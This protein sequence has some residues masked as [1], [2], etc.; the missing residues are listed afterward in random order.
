MSSVSGLGY[1]PSVTPADIE[2]VWAGNVSATGATINA[3]S[4]GTPTLLYGTD[5]GLTDPDNLSGTEGNDDVWSF[6][7]SGLSADTVYYYSFVGWGLTATFRTFPTE[8]TAHS[9]SIAAASCAGQSGGDYEVGD[10]SNTPTLDHIA[11]RDLAL[12]IHLGDRGYPDITTDSVSAFRTNYNANM[13]MTKQAA[14]HRAM[15]VAYVWDDHDF[16]DN[17]SHAATASKPAAQTVYR[18]HVP[19]WTLPSA[20]GIYQTF[21][22]GRVRFIL[23]DGRSFKSNPSDTDDSSKTLLGATQKQ[24]VK[25]TLDNSTEPV[26]VL[27]VAVPW[28]ATSSLPD[29]WGG[30]STERQELAEFFEDNSH[31]ERLWLLHG[32]M[33]AIMGDDGANTQFDPGSANDGPPLSGFA[34]MDAGATTYSGTYTISPSTDSKQQYG[35]LE[36]TDTGSQITVT[37]RA[38][39]VAG[40]GSESEAWNFSKVYT[41]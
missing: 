1:A 7:L 3:R 29:S 23:I 30:Y 28:N 25:D 12:F 8:G 21:V 15:P 41:G 19:H 39:E 24:W 10:V 9:F 6:D 35:T 32:D 16:G 4:D 17:N 34:P 37:A 38:Y 33:H 27:D 36:F 13:A 5:A 2:W 26:V 18:E 40:I 31:T 20:S 14:L 11:A 22:I